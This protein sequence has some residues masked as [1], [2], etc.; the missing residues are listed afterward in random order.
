ML[1]IGY[2]QGRGER[3]GTLSVLERTHKVVVFGGG[4]FGTAVGTA[5]ARQ[6]SDLA[7]SLLLRD[8]YVCKSI[9]DTH[10]NLRYLA[11]ST[12]RRH[13]WR[14]ACIETPDRM[15]RVVTIY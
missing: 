12:D 11:V 15:H 4:S 13:T 8:P 14:A 5:L 6:K 10:R 1:A 9:N 7:V 3:S 2:L